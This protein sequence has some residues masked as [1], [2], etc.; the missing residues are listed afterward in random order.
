MIIDGQHGLIS[1]HKVT[2]GAA[3]AAA[4]IAT[5][6][7]LASLHQPGA[8]ARDSRAASE[9][10]LIRPFPHFA[11]HLATCLA[12]AA[13]LPATAE[14]LST[15]S[16][17]V[18]VSL[19]A[20]QDAM[21]RALPNP[22]VSDRSEQTCIPAERMCTDIPE[23]RGLK[24][25]RRRECIDITPRIGCDIEQVVVREGKVDIAEEGGALR[26]SQV[27]RGQA[28]VRGRGDIGKNIRETANGVARLTLTVIPRVT[29]DWRIEADI[30]HGI[31]WPQPPTARLFNLIDVTFQSKATE[32]LS[33]AI[34]AYRR[35]RLP[36]DLAK[37]ALRDRMA[38]L[39]ADLQAPIPV[40]VPQG[41]P[42]YLHFRPQDVAMAPFTIADET[43]ST[44]LS[45]TG[46]FLL[47]DAATPDSA[48]LPLP[49]LSPAPA[50]AGV[51]LSVP[52]VLRLDRLS[53][54]ASA[55]LPRRLT[56]F[57]PVRHTIEIRSVTFAEAPGGALLSRLQTTISALGGSF[58]VPL[59][60]AGR[61]EWNPDTR[62]L[63]LRDPQLRFS[64]EGI[65][66]EVLTYIAATPVATARIANLAQLSLDD[67]IGALEAE[68]IRALDAE[69]GANLE[70]DASLQL[71]VSDLNVDQ[72][73]RL[74]FHAQ[75]AVSLALRRL[76]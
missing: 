37:I 41:E 76:E 36:D 26:I 16:V 68:L 38:A 62:T 65:A 50:V 13:A 67:R 58:D 20:L 55:T 8:T 28:T 29:A 74:T 53:G 23:F 21:E 9:G 69:L 42:L 15:L 48:P 19:A 17:P 70:A 43:V 64:A 22:L 63:A 66:A 34:E 56:F 51:D 60:L 25:Y 2:P 30:G 27:L 47:T 59:T 73:L 46:R 33:G 4:E 7:M 24:I 1:V 54:L 18:A 32:K 14:P 45:L 72:G 44:R 57:Q 35:D 40:P 71:S 3:M 6:E 49:D 12:L 10:F 75:G 61:P 31:E 11:A 39:W 52:V 5:G